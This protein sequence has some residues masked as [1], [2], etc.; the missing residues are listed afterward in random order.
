[1]L[2]AFTVD[3]V[4]LREQPA[5]FSKRWQGLHEVADILA[6]VRE[7]WCILQS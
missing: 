6:E 3:L 2:L 4:D 7:G 5:L 1:M